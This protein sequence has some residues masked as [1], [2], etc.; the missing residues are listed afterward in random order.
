MKKRNVGGEF[1]E[2]LAKEGI[3]EELTAIAVKRVICL[4]DRAGDGRSKAYQDGD[5]EKNA[6]QPR[7]A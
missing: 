7:F 1:D 5:G 3:L 2:I 4:A 6:N